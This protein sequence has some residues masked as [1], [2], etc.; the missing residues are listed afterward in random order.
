MEPKEVTLPAELGVFA[1]QL[2]ATSLDHLTEVIDKIEAL[3]LKKET[4]GSTYL[5]HHP[6]FLSLSLQIIDSSFLVGFF[7]E[8]KSLKI[9]ASFFEKLN[10]KTCFRFSAKL[11]KHS[12]MGFRQSQDVS[13]KKTDLAFFSQFLLVLIPCK[14]VKSGSSFYSLDE[15]GMKI[16]LGEEGSFRP[17]PPN[18]FSLILIFRLEIESDEKVELASCKV[19]D[20]LCWEVFV[21]ENKLWLINSLENTETLVFDKI[22][23]K[24]SKEFNFLFVGNSLS[25]LSIQL[26]EEPPFR[27]GAALGSAIKESAG[28]EL[29]LFRGGRS[30]LSFIGGFGKT[31]DAGG[32]KQAF[33]AAISE[34]GVDLFGAIS[35]PLSSPAPA[36][37]INAAA[38]EWNDFVAGAS[39]DCRRGLRIESGA[40][41]EDSLLAVRVFDGCVALLNYV[42]NE[43]DLLSV[44]RLLR[45]VAERPQLFLTVGRRPFREILA[46]LALKDLPL[47]F[48][49]VEE[50]VALGFEAGNESASL[51]VKDFFLGAEFLG[52]LESTEVAKV[53]FDSLIAR[54]DAAD[55]STLEP[56]R[57]LE[58]LIIWAGSPCVAAQLCRLAVFLIDIARTTTVNNEGEE[59]GMA[60][61]LA[62]YV[63]E[64]APATRDGCLALLGRLE[65]VSPS[66]NWRES[67]VNALLRVVAGS[68][69]AE[70]IARAVSL[71]LELD[72]GCEGPM[73]LL[74]RRRVLGERSNANSREA[75][76]AMVDSKK[77]AANDT[78]AAVVCSLLSDSPASSR[79]TSTNRRKQGG[80]PLLLLAAAADSDA[81]AVARRLAETRVDS[82]RFR[83]SGLFFWLLQCGLAGDQSL[84][85]IS[86]R[87]L[88]EFLCVSRA[89][90]DVSPLL[91]LLDSRLGGNYAAAL[92]AQLCSLEDPPSLSDSAGLALARAAR[93][94]FAA[95]PFPPTA[96][97]LLALLR[98]EAPQNRG[99]LRGF[100][101]AASALRSPSE[102]SEK[103]LLCIVEEGLRAGKQCESAVVTALRAL[104]AFSPLA[105]A[106]AQAL[107]STAGWVPSLAADSAD[108]TMTESSE[109]TEA[110]ANCATFEAPI[111]RDDGRA[112]LVVSGVVRQMRKELQKR[113]ERLQAKAAQRRQDGRHALR[114][115]YRAAHDWNGPLARKGTLTE[116][117]ADVGEYDAARGQVVKFKHDDT[118]TADL[119]RPFLKM[120]LRR[121]YPKLVW[122]E[123]TQEIGQAIISETE[124]QAQAPL[125]ENEGQG[126]TL[127]AQSL[128]AG[129]V[130]GGGP[131]YVCG[132]VKGLEYIPSLVS[133]DSSKDRIELL[134][135]PGSFFDSSQME[136][137]SYHFRPYSRLLRKFPF[138]QVE[139]IHEHRFLHSM[140]AILFILRS[141]KRILLDFQSRGVMLDFSNRIFLI[142]PAWR[143]GFSARKNFRIQKLQDRWLEGNISTFGYLMAINEAGS[144]SYLDFSQY[145]VFPFLKFWSESRF[146]ELGLPMG[147]AGNP[148]RAATFRRRLSAKDQFAGLAPYAFGSCYSSPAIVMH[149]LL[150]LR[151]YAAGARELQNGAFDLPDRLFFSILSLE[152]NLTE[153]TA[154]VREALPEMFCLPS[155]FLNINHFDFGVNQ[156]RRRVHHVLFPSE[157][158]T[159]DRY[160]ADLR[161]TLESP[162][163]AATLGEWIDL[164]FGMRASG[165]GAAEVANVFFPL[166]YESSLEGVMKEDPKSRLASMT[167]IYHFGQVPTQVF[168]KKHPNRK[169]IASPALASPR[170]QLKHFVRK[171]ET[172][173]VGEALAVKVLSSTTGALVI[174]VRWSVVQNF[175]FNGLLPGADSTRPPFEFVLSSDT[176]LDKLWKLLPATRAFEHRASLE[177]LT[178]NRLAVGGFR[179]GQVLL[180]STKSLRVISEIRL[181]RHCVSSIYCGGDQWLLSMDVSGQVGVS[182]FDSE[183]DNFAPLFLLRDFFGSRELRANFCRADSNFFVLCSAERIEVRSVF[184]P[185]R[186][187]F[188]HAASSNRVFHLAT[189]SLSPV[190]CLVVF[191]TGANGTGRLESIGLNGLPIAAYDFEGIAWTE[192]TVGASA[193]GQGVPIGTKITELLVL[194]DQNY[195]DGLAA[196]DSSGN[197]FFF[198]LPFFENGRKNRASHKLALAHLAPLNFDRSLM[199]VDEKGTLSFVSVVGG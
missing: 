65:R 2:P 66:R 129:S 22:D 26:N 32:L 91:S 12:M 17:M 93:R 90:G 146:R 175:K 195:C 74:W 158:G 147:L 64:V 70:A 89:S 35:G 67:A 87:L 46:G 61:V 37:L 136:I 86:C 102:A 160:V 10:R 186:P 157:C 119:A 40:D 152:R 69:S 194:Q 169:L 43:R 79:Q 155:M 54:L 114:E 153:E 59:A 39:V 131:W 173:P 176:P 98:R 140:R 164:I 148:R 20:L 174:V 92:L 149:F 115:L 197:V 45:R 123:G 101:I 77:L 125:M 4:M 109:A 55:H 82:L 170:A 58:A 104:L 199:L 83:G 177:V 127:M 19:G 110:A 122:A 113:V 76:A 143:A 33:H 118:V 182:R 134:V 62:L 21:R 145:P 34:Q 49:V 56:R 97:A 183:I 5:T 181:H 6:G 52:R 167:Q 111:P 27:L 142:R 44:V 63:E 36:M 28:S 112:E 179:E 105:A 106:K 128:V 94:F 31:F 130:S 9:L 150:R 8:E 3:I 25:H 193:V 60:V 191:V 100:A 137:R 198:D 80:L 192:S 116:L 133:I 107:I 53:A 121:D 78:F 95:D 120:R 151:P 144:R 30:E 50:L 178:K 184:K 88:A 172:G 42:E 23:Q 14:S 7:S 29:W 73:E 185:H 96:T 16:S 139:R 154:D 108:D 163:I 1:S 18:I 68:E 75:F 85:D 117:A 24:L 57:V 190:P 51:F 138:S 132:R 72:A 166:T 99:A 103:L 188:A 161:V 84:R 15:S 187:L 11:I 156:S 171:S 126:Q 48:E 141:G 162:R 135:N 124:G 13:K 189:L 38:G 81:I 41:C 71:A 165:L 168:S 47:T 159:A 180:V 196:C